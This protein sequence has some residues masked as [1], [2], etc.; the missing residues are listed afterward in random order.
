MT[1]RT[2]ARTAGFGAMLALPVAVSAQSWRTFDVAR[3]MQGAEP[4]D[5][6]V[7][8]GAG[9]VEVL[10]ATDRSLFDVHLRYDAERAEPIYRFDSPQRR[11][12]VGVRHFSNVRAGRGYKGSELQVALAR[13]VPMQLDLD[14]GAA[15][16]E[17]NLTGL[18]LDA[19]SV[20]GGATEI[21]MRFDA[22]NPR[23]MA[24]MRIDAGAASVKVFGLGHANAERIDA[25]IGVGSLDLDFGGAWQG[26]LELSVTSALGSVDLAVPSNVGVRVEKTSFLHSFSAPDLEKRNGYWVSD[27][28]DSAQYKLRIRATGTL[29][30]LEI[31]RISR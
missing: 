20:K 10:P 19:L 11:L 2:I 8:F 24:Q 4:L 30:S 18:H 28:W 1:I 21:R 29:G 26:D 16:G 31:R 25:N 7:A 15:E 3:Q 9:R 6:H 13:G 12:E 17:I 5:V 27:N 14:V 23:R 22:G